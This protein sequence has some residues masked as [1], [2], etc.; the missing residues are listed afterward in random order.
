[1]QPDDTSHVWIGT[2]AG[3]L[4]RADAITGLRCADGSAEAI[5]SDGRIIRLAESAC[6]PD[7]HLQLLRELARARTDTRWLVIIGAE[8]GRDGVRWIQC[9]V[10]DL[11]DHDKRST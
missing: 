4:V 5:C 2:A 10:D 11:V 7:F 1:M 8:Q 3:E 9:R 6:P